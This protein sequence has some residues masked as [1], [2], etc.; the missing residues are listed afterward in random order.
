FVETGKTAPAFDLILLGLGEDGHTASLFPGSRLL[1]EET[2]WVAAEI[3]PAINPPRITLTLPII[4]RAACVLFLVAGRN[5]AEV[6]KRVVEDGDPELPAS[7]VR[8]AS[9]RLIFAVDRPAAY[10]LKNI[11]R[12]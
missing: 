9:G 1:S 11:Q 6:L 10:Y 8:P 7:L 5:K 12:L 3:S 2:R 4:N